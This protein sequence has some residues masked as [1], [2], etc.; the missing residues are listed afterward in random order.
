MHA[1]VNYSINK[2]KHKIILTSTEIDE[3]VHHLII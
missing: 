3:V 1:S 2:N